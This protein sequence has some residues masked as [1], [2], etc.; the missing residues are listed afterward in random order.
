MRRVLAVAVGMLLLAVPSAS[1]AELQAAYEHY[2]P[3]ESFQIGL[4]NAATGAARPL[5]AGVNTTDDELAPALSPDRRWL[6]FTRMRI[7]PKLDGTFVVPTGNLVLVD[8]QAQTVQAFPQGARRA[9]PTFM[10]G[11]RL[12]ADLTWGITPLVLAPE[13]GATI[14][15]RSLQSQQ[16]P[17]GNGNSMHVD[18]DTNELFRTRA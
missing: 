10:T 11:G 2:V 14:I 8:L 12:A 17:N 18:V 4:V 9:G 3:G 13:P 5:P 6:V 15:A 16:L 1:A 7:L